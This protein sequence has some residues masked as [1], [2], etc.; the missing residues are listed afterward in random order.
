MSLS[1]ILTTGMTEKTSL[2]VTMDLTCQPLV[3]VWPLIKNLIHFSD[4]KLPKFNEPLPCE[5]S[6]RAGLQSRYNFISDY[7]HMM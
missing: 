7:D 6:G 3:G 2:V 4:V 5:T 1:F